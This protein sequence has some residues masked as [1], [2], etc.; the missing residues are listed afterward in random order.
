MSHK[1]E[2][3]WRHMYDFSI[4]HIVNNLSKFEELSL[5]RLFS[6]EKKRK[7]DEQHFRT[8]KDWRHFIL[9]E[10]YIWRI[11]YVYSHSSSTTD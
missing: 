4:A 8:Q 9:Y 1:Y 11:W 3:L 7:V 6:K 10:S 5:C 2:S